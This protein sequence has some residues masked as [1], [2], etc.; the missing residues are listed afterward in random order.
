MFLFSSWL[1]IS[2]SWGSFKNDTCGAI[3]KRALGIRIIRGHISLDGSTDDVSVQDQPRY[4][5]LL[6]LSTTVNSEMFLCTQSSCVKGLAHRWW[7]GYQEVLE[8][9]LNLTYRKECKPLGCALEWGI[10]TFTLFLPSSLP[11][12][13]SV[14][15]LS[16]S[17]PASWPQW[18]EQDL[19]YVRY[20]MSCSAL[21]RDH[22]QQNQLDWPRNGFFEEVEK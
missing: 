9:F 18:S 4:A 20:V 8:P 21:P 22:K 14:L 3:G 16:L 13:V 15:F 1:H 11:L 5:V 7:Y 17:L 6:D 12:A 10:E 2:I 19:H